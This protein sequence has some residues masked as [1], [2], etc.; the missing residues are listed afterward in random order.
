MKCHSEMYLPSPRV[1]CTHRA[2]HDDQN[3]IHVVR[4]AGL[5]SPLI[6]F[7][8]LQ[9]HT[10]TSTLVPYPFFP[11]TSDIAGNDWLCTSLSSCLPIIHLHSAAI[12]WPQLAPIPM[13][14]RVWDDAMSRGPTHVW[15]SQLLWDAASKSYPH[16]GDP[17]MTVRKQY[18]VFCGG[19]RRIHENCASLGCLA[20]SETDSDRIVWYVKVL[21]RRERKKRRL[22]LATGVYI[23]REDGSQERRKYICRQRPM[24]NSRVSKLQLKDCVHLRYRDRRLWGTIEWCPLESS[25]Q[26][27]PRHS[28]FMSIVLLTMFDAMHR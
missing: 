12:G 2:R 5:S 24:R 17:F 19:R 7:S 16:P 15:F 4:H 27:R 25:T 26:R 20:S 21:A 8:S 13:R 6:L 28:S 18:V 23:D 10:H 9:E 11:F 1:E 3:D 14:S 22:W